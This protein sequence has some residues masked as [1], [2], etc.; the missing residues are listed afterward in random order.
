MQ[1]GS[2]DEDENDT[3]P[4][5]SVIGEFSPSLTF[6]LTNVYSGEDGDNLTFHRETNRCAREA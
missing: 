3:R 6:V 5:D 1:E 2:D 4:R